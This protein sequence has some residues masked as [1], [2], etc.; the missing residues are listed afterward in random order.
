MM[1]GIDFCQ[2][3]LLSVRW[4]RVVMLNSGSHH[5]A[6]GAGRGCLSL[7]QAHTVSSHGEIVRADEGQTFKTLL[8]NGADS[9]RC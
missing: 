2:S 8:E 7:T 6:D 3:P 1:R 9:N 5:D 4:N